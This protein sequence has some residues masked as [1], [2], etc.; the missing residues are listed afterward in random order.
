MLLEQLTLLKFVARIMPLEQVLV[1]FEKLLA[2]EVVLEQN[3]LEHSSSRT[4]CTGR[5]SCPSLSQIENL[6]SSKS[7]S[8]AIVR[9]G[10]LPL[11][12]FP[13]RGIV[14]E[15]KLL[16]R[17][18]IK[19]TYHRAVEGERTN[20][21][22]FNI[23][24]QAQSIVP[25]SIYTHTHTRIY[26]YKVMENDDGGGSSKKERALRL[27]AAAEE[28]VQCIG[29]GYDLTV[30][31]RLKYCKK[32]QITKE[33]SRLIAMDDDQVWDI[34]VPGG[35]L[36][37]NVP[38]S[39]HS[40]KGDRVRFSSDVLSFQQ[41]SEQFNQDLSLSGKIPTGHFNAAFELTG[42]WQKYAAFTKSLAFEGVFI[43]LYSIALEKAQ[44]TLRDH[45]KEAV[46]SS[47]DPA[48]LAR[49]IEKYGTHVIVGVKMGGK[50]IIYVKQQFSS[51]LEPMDVQ[52]RLK[53]VADKRFSDTSEQSGMHPE[54]A[55]DSEMH[56]S[57]ERGST[58]LDLSAPSFHSN[59][60]EVTFFWRR[61]GGSNIRNMPHNMWCQTVQLEPEVISMSFIPISSLLNGIDGSGFLGHAINLYLRYKPP[62]EELRQFLEF[63]LPRK[64][65]PE[66]GEIPIGPD[67]KLKGAASLQFSWM[68]PKLYV[69]ADELDVGNTPVTGLRLYLEGRRSNCLAI[70]LQHLS[71]LPK[72]FHL[73]NESN[74]NKINSYDRRYYEK[75]QWKSFSHICTAP[76]ESDD[77]LSIVTGAQFEVKASGMKDVLFI[78]L[79]FSKVSDATVMKKPEW[80]GSSVLAQKSG[81]IPSLI[82]FLSTVQKPPEPSDVNINSAIHKGPPMPAQTL[83]FLR[84][85]DTTEMTRGPQDSPGYWV[86]SGA[87]LV[88]DNGKISVCVK[89]SLL[90][91]I[92]QDEEVLLQG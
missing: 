37:Q 71:S 6:C 38:K 9:T 57:N 32:Q 12:H 13:A 17:T 58:V 63:Q 84:F 45:V 85:V 47:W 89:Y 70:H 81:I 75:V 28:A 80:D 60:E 48:A 20:D 14:L 74:N 44:V 36:V 24:A 88:V 33:G 51:P 52:K 46:P 23:R 10:L 27:R 26:I 21:G 43:T 18:Q 91:V 61:R 59:Q 92:L 34:A 65:A 39:I 4:N 5:S 49:F 86:V 2:Q 29:L 41:M 8:S 90:A 64:W 15:Q 3:P 53:V 77:D 54:E 73:R 82:S 1:P 42:C 67:R 19:E 40:D 62:I 69:N 16:E 31:L 30:E 22:K 25:E 76:V 72:S 87:R 11:D 7:L 35:I 78:S 50:D 66:F 68:G 56:E 55:Y 79:H 83:K